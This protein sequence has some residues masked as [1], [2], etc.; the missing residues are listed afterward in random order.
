MMIAGALPRRDRIASNGCPQAICRREASVSILPH[1]DGPVR[2]FAHV[3]KE[4]SEVGD[5]AMVN[6]DPSTAKIA[7]TRRGGIGADGVH[8]LP[9]P[10]SRIVALGRTPPVRGQAS[11]ASF[12]MQAAATRGAARADVTAIGGDLVA[13]VAGEQPLRPPPAADPGECQSD[14]ATEAQPRH[15][16]PNLAPHVMFS[17]LYTV[18][19]NTHPG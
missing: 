7:V 13:A 1:E 4:A 18:E 14:Q 17:G 19:Y 3:G 15:I 5:P 9:G 2:P 16:D 10:V 6:R 12:P 11:G 8:L